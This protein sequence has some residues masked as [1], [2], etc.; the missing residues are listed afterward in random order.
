MPV[1][2]LC[3]T[4]HDKTFFLFQSLFRLNLEHENEHGMTCFN[5]YS[6]IHSNLIVAACVFL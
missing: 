6:N 4:G 1:P 3:N 5:Q 2:W